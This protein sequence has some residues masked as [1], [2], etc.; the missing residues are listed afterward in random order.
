[1]T[2]EPKPPYRRQILDD[3]FDA[4]VI[5]GKG[6]YVSLYD[7]VGQMTRYS[8]ASVELF[9]LVGEY[10]P[11]GAMNWGDWVHPEDRMRIQGTAK[12]YD[13]HYRVRVKDGSYSLMRFVGSILRN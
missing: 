10:V 9:G 2:E 1:M 5:L 12:H 7:V 4:Y 11:A 3:L 8:P 13:L 6:T